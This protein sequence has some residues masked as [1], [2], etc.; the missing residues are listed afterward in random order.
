ME[1]DEDDEGDDAEVLGDGDGVFHRF[2]QVAADD[3][4]VHHH[5]FEEGFV[6]VVVVVSDL[7]PSVRYFTPFGPRR[8]R[9]SGEGLVHFGRD[10][11]YGDG[12]SKK[13]LIERKRENTLR[14][15]LRICGVFCNKIKYMGVIGNTLGFLQQLC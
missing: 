8:S 14:K 5:L 10:S 7:H 13:R 4:G 1:P 11:S 15:I 3:V 9:V 2:E 6:C 12:G